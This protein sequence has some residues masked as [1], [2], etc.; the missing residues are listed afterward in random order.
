MNFRTDCRVHTTW[1]ASLLIASF[2]VNRAKAQQSEP[3]YQQPDPTFIGSF[4]TIDTPV[5]VAYDSASDT[6]WTLEE[7]AS[8]TFAV[9]YSTTGS[10]QQSFSLDSA[11]SPAGD[12][13]VLPQQLMIGSTPVPAGNL[14]LVGTDFLS[15][16]I[17]AI[18]S[19]NGST[20]AIQSLING[21]SP[22]L[23]PSIGITVRD[24]GILDLNTNGYVTAL[25]DFGR[26]TIEDLSRDGS[27]HAIDY[28]GGGDVHS[29]FTTGNLFVVSNDQPA[30]RVRSRTVDN[31]G[32]RWEIDLQVEVGT[33][34]FSGIAYDETEEETYLSSS[35][36]N[37]V[38]V[39]GRDS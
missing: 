26:P 9:Q 18:D 31:I 10:F 3:T 36:T 23:A 5:G 25:T 7:A 38:Y 17:V 34:G 28:S 33:S 35:E 20:L 30:V 2:L 22:P 16:N 29:S 1:I 12:I 21:F 8:E 24:S 39:I 6:V 37:E 32:F 4:T 11:T 27:G 15:T 14:L 13:Y 19:T